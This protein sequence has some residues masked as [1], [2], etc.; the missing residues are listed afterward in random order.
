MGPITFEHFVKALKGKKPSADT[1]ALKLLEEYN[2][3]YMKQK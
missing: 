2:Q 1:A 3:D